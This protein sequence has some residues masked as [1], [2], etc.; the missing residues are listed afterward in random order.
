LA[1]QISPG[2]PLSDSADSILERFKL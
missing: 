2:L 1:E